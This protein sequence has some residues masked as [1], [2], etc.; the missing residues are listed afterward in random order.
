MLAFEIA[1]RVQPSLLDGGCMAFSHDEDWMSVLQELNEHRT[2]EGNELLKK[3]CE[4]FKFVAEGGVI[5]TERMTSA[6]YEFMQRGSGLVSNNV[7]LMPVL[8]HLR[9]PDASPE[10]DELQRTSTTTTQDIRL[11]P[12]DPISDHG[13]RNTRFK[14]GIDSTPPQSSSKRVLMACTE[15]RKRKV[16]CNPDRSGV[17]HPCERCDRHGLRCR[18][19]PISN[20]FP[21]HDPGA[22][23]IKLFDPYAQ[24]PPAHY[25][26]P[27]R[28][29]ACTECHKRKVRCN[30]GRSGA[31]A[32]EQ[33]QTNG[34]E[35][36]NAPIFPNRPIMAG[37]APL[38]PS[39]YTMV[40]SRSSPNTVPVR[41]SDG[42]I[43]Y[44]TPSCFCG[45]HPKQ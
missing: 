20:F 35:C 11:N 25:P 31:T 43:C 22:E 16:R 21:E 40:P 13:N 19:E 30:P 7:N 1:S 34:L 38:R 45:H 24:I 3:V 37:G 28:A 5:Y 4:K 42:R 33:C 27:Q 2:P 39:D 10:P 36:R 15:C 44:G 8:F 23:G 18:Y 17:T 14:S 9:E 32:C 26:S 29:I 12:E 6:E 41:L